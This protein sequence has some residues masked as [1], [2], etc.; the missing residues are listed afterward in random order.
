MHRTITAA[1]LVVAV[2]FSP[3][4]APAYPNSDAQYSLTV[5]DVSW[6]VLQ[7][8]KDPLRWYY[9]PAVAN[10]SE[11]GKRQPAI[12]ILKYQTL[13]PANNQMLINNTLLLLTL[14]LAPEKA[15]LE[16]LAKG[17][18][19]L[20]PM[21]ERKAA[22]K[23]ISLESVRL[24]EAKVSLS[25]A[26]GKPLAEAAAIEAIGP[27]VSAA[28]ISFY[29]KTEGETADKV[30]KLLTDTGGGKVAVDYAY[31]AGALKPGAARPGPT[32]FRRQA[33]CAVS[34]GAY[35]KEVQDKA[36]IIFPPG[37]PLTAFF[38]LPAVADIAGFTEVRYTVRIM[39]PDGKESKQAPAQ[40]TMWGAKGGSAGWRD[41]RGNFRQTLLFPVLAL[42]DQAKAAGKDLAAFKY[43]VKGEAVLSRGPVQEITKAEGDTAFLSGGVAFAAAY[44][45]FRVVSVYGDFLTFMT[46]DI[47]SDLGAVQV[48]LSCGKQRENLAIRADKD[49]TLN[50]NPST[51]FFDKACGSV[52]LQAEYIQKNGKKSKKVFS[53]LVQGQDLAVYL[54]NYTE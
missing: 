25:D 54:E 42:Y 52:S 12:T 44:S 11:I 21:L 34:L 19:G 1:V 43:R 33:S 47:T 51:A 5:K 45:P 14:N 7:D 46:Q 48:L 27:G 2:L 10:L 3:R 17:V 24:N 30:E 36:V 16:E 22:A 18:A 9:L 29:L 28:G 26:G 13:A 31:T 35:P 41:Q 38:L 23:D 6:T 4:P 53:D 49:G 37:N 20:N 15:V 39:D 8:H 50:T 32:V 40:L